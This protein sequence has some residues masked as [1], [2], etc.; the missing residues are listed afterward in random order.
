MGRSEAGGGGGGLSDGTPS[1]R[2][3]EAHAGWL[4]K[5][6]ESPHF[7]LL[8]VLLTVSDVTMALLVTKDEFSDDVMHMT[9][10]AHLV[11]MTLFIIELTTRLSL[12]FYMT[13]TIP[14]DLLT[15]IDSAAVILGWLF[16]LMDPPTL[17]ELAGDSNAKA[18]IVARMARLVRLMLLLRV[19]RLTRF[20]DLEAPHAK[21][22]RLLQSVFKVFEELQRRRMLEEVYFCVPGRGGSPVRVR[23]TS[24]AIYG[25]MYGRARPTSTDPPQPRLNPRLR[26][27]RYAFLLPGPTEEPNASLRRPRQQEEEEEVTSRLLGASGRAQCEAAQLRTH[28]HWREPLEAVPSGQSR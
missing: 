17:E 9:N 18:M 21:R 11:V 16:A 24:T 1:A 23:G 5:L 27:Y 28:V 25:L 4:L 15:I 6:I 14:M 3:R 7:V 12:H 26:L 20:R 2:K 13:G 19:T 10:V 22:N 8:V